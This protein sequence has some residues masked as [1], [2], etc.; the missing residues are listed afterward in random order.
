MNRDD[1]ERLAQ[2][3]R[4]YDPPHWDD[5]ERIDKEEYESNRSDWFDLQDALTTLFDELLEPS[6]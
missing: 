2:R 3:V 6:A 1:L 4:L 5:P